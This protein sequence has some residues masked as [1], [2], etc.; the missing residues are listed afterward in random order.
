MGKKRPILAVPN[1]SA[2]QQLQQQCPASPND[3]AKQW[4]LAEELTQGVGA[5]NLTYELHEEEERCLDAG[6]DPE[7]MNM[8]LSQGHTENCRSLVCLPSPVP[9]ASA[10]VHVQ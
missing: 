10:S 3:R 8:L 2:Q 7:T 1:A 4:G 9:S 5:G 6:I